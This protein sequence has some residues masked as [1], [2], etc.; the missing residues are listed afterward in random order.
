MVHLGSLLQPEK[1]P[2]NL[3]RYL[4]QVYNNNVAG[5]GATRYKFISTDKEPNMAYINVNLDTALVFIPTK[6]YTADGKQYTYVAISSR[7]GNSDGYINFTTSCDSTTA[8]W[9]FLGANRAANKGYVIVNNL[10]GLISKVESYVNAATGE[11]KNQIRL[12]CVT[13]DELE[14][15][16]SPATKSKK[17]TKNNQQELPF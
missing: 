12:N 16:A 1:V 4:V 10:H 6:S 14:G 8:L 9:K 17:P 13:F 15:F 2:P 5:R 7:P 11:V 3:T